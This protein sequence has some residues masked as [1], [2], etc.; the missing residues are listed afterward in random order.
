MERL[1]FHFNFELYFLLQVTKHITK[2]NGA[3][4]PKSNIVSEFNY[5]SKAKPLL[6]INI[7]L[8]I[9]S[10]LFIIKRLTF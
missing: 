10:N 9:Y 2:G 3:H 1:T 5:K 8:P 6:Q 7:A 4:I